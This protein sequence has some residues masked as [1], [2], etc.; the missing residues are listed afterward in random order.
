MF[1]AC[2]L[3]KAFAKA[4]A[5]FAET[6]MQFWKHYICDCIKN[7]AWNN[8]TKKSMSGIQKKTLK[9]FVPD[10]IEFPKDEEFA[11]INKAVIKMAVNLNLVWISMAIH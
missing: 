9:R 3:R 4:I 6:L 1:K 8:I 7:I 11:K 2:Y 5:T 10:F